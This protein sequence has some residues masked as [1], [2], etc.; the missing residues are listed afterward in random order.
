MIATTMMPRLTPEDHETACGYDDIPRRR[1]RLA[2][3]SAAIDAAVMRPGPATEPEP[4]VPGESQS[5]IAG[6]FIGLLPARL[7]ALGL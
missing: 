5:T 4:A 3:T 2:A 6:R 7:R 1:E